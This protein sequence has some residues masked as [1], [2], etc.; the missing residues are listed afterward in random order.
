MNI[1]K[2]LN[3]VSKAANGINSLDL[4]AIGYENY[5][6]LFVDTI[7]SNI[8]YSNMDGGRILTRIGSREKILRM[9]YPDVKHFSAGAKWRIPIEIG[10]TI[11][12]HLK[13]MLPDL[14]FG[15][16]ECWFG[17]W[18]LVK[19]PHDYI[20]PALLGH[21]QFSEFQPFFLIHL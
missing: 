1:N 4:G 14:E 9:F 7:H 12:G 20:F 8:P 19:T 11:G 18:M 5:G 16:H 17:V 10:I 15:G 6:F 3:I 13:T 2:L 21:Y